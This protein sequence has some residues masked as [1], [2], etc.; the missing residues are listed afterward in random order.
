MMGGDW[1]TTQREADPLC[2]ICNKKFTSNYI[3]C[4]L[5]IY[6][7][8]TAGKKYVSTRAGKKYKSTKK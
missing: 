6:I 5:S 1:E 4:D 3:G 8:A 7:S 2:V